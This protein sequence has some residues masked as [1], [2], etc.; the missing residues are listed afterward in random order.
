M[1]IKKRLIEDRIAALSFVA[2]NPDVREL[3]KYWPCIAVVIEIEPAAKP[4]AEVVAYVYEID[5][6]RS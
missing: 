1:K 3:P 6:P 4:C 5:F 2:E